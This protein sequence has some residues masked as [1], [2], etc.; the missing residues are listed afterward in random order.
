MGM[1]ARIQTGFDRSHAPA[2]ERSPGRSGARLGPAPWDVFDAFPV[3][4]VG[5]AVV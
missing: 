2:W 3:D 1:E 4:R 5:D